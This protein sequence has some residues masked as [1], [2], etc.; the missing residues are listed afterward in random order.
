MLIF[1]CNRKFDE[2][3]IISRKEVE[4]LGNAKRGWTK[5]SKPK[6][7]TAAILEDENASQAKKNAKHIV[8]SATGLP[9]TPLELQ[10]DWNRLTSEKRIG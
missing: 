5:S 10:R 2:S 6:K 9:R 8:Q 3:L 7:P 4:S 1:D